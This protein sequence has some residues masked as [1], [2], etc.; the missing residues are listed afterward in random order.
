[1]TAVSLIQLVKVLVGEAGQEEV[2][3]VCQQV[4]GGMYQLLQA[5]TVLDWLD[6]SIV[7]VLMVLQKMGSGNKAAVRV[8]LCH[9]YLLA[10]FSN[11][12]G[13]IQQRVNR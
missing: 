5:G 11:I 6:K 8:A 9:A 3:V 2:T 12:A 4:L 7:V 1:M 10:L 13:V